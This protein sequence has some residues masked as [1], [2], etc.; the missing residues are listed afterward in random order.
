[1]SP[2]WVEKVLSPYP[3]DYPGSRSAVGDCLKLA[4]SDFEEQ[5]ALIVGYEHDPPKIEAQT[6]IEALDL[7]TEEVQGVRRGPRQEGAAADLVHDLF[8]QSTVYGRKIEP[9][10]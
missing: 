1:V 4:R 8:R 2:Y 5:T 7:I 10:R 9:S 3:D 6:A